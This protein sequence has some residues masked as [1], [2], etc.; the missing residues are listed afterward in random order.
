MWRGDPDNPDD[1][2]RSLTLAQL[3]SYLPGGFQYLSLQRELTESEQRAVAAHPVDFISWQ[4]LN[5]VETAAL[6]ECLDLVISVD[7]SIAHL[8]AALGMKT[9]ILLSFHPDWRWLL[10]RRD[11]PWYPSVNLYRQ[12][13]EDDWSP[14][15]ASL[16]RDLAE[17]TS[18]AQPE[19]S[20][21]IRAP[22][23]PDT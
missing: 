12:A 21:A 19:A 8:S 18:D 6:C 5:F 13:T 3:L 7:T 17:V 14:V 20:N 10:E 1:R 23:V 22:S 4:D 16:R 2:R 11:S 15:F 9:W